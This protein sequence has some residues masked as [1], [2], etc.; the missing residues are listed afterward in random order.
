[1]ALKSPKRLFKSLVCAFLFYLYRKITIQLRKSDIYCRFGQGLRSPFW[2]TPGPH[3]VRI[4]LLWFPLLRLLKN[5]QK[6]LPIHELFI[7]YKLTLKRINCHIEI[8]NLSEMGLFHLVRIPHDAD[9]SW[10]QK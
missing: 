6:L 3:L 2:T 4:P 9:F 1:M 8:M 5:F 7:R 10:S